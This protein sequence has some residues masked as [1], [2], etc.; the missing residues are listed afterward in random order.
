MV[1]QGEGFYKNE[2]SKLFGKFS[3]NLLK[4]LLLLL[5][6]LCVCKH[7]SLGYSIGGVFP[8]CPSNILLKIRY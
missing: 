1:P 2:V 8:P 5:M 3:F 6:M 4:L 7:S